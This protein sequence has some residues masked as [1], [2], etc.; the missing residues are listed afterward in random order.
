M[1]AFFWF[2]LIVFSS[3]IVFIYIIPFLVRIFLRRLAKRFQNY[4]EKNNQNTTKPE[5]TVNIDYTGDQPKK[6]TDIGDYVDYEE[7]KDK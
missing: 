3:W 2:L 1:N 7:I 4:A 6:S 5:G